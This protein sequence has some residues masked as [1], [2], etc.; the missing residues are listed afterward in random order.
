[1][2]GNRQNIHLRCWDEDRSRSRNT[3]PKGNGAHCRLG[4]KCGAETLNCRKEA[5]GGEDNLSKKRARPVKPLEQET[6]GE[7]D[8]DNSVKTRD[9]LL[10]MARPAKP[11][12]QVRCDCSCY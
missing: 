2:A 10:D 3:V 7:C 4:T 11:L 1:M 9:V 8:V 12:K 5:A 6:V